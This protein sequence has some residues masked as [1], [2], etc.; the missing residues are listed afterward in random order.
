MGAEELNAVPAGCLNLK[1]SVSPR[2]GKPQVVAW[3][4]FESK[5]LPEKCCRDS[6]S[7]AFASSSTDD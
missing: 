4:G 2:I 3:V 1:T 6:Y 5:V 7:S